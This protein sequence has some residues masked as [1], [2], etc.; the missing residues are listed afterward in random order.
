[1]FYHKKEIKNDIQLMCIKF[2]H[3]IKFEIRSSRFHSIHMAVSHLWCGRTSFKSFWD[4][5]DHAWGIF[6]CFVSPF[7]SII[8]TIKINQIHMKVIINFG[9][10]VRNVAVPNS[11]SYQMILTIL[12]LV[13][14]I[15]I[16]A[17]RVEPKWRTIT[18]FSV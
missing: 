3:N 13:D 2:S 6:Y 7:H 14:W 11:S 5:L 16:L 1:M 9:N 18:E 12:V 8:I 10:C 4:E 17:S 15:W